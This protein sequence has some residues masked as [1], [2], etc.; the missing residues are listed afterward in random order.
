MVNQDYERRHLWNRDYGFRKDY[1]RGKRNTQIDPLSYPETA[2]TAQLR[3]NSY[4]S[5]KQERAAA[6]PLV[7]LSLSRSQPSLH[8][9]SSY[10][11]EASHTSEVAPPAWTWKKRVV[12]SLPS[13]HPAYTSNTKQDYD[14]ERPLTLPHEE[15]MERL[16]FVGELVSDENSI[17]KLTGL[18]PGSLNK[19][20]MRWC[21]VPPLTFRPG[22]PKPDPE[23]VEDDPEAPPPPVPLLAEITDNA[24]RRI[25][26]DV[27]TD[28]DFHEI[29]SNEDQAQVLA[30]HIERNE[31]EWFKS[32]ME[33]HTF[34]SSKTHP[35][36]SMSCNEVM[37]MYKD[38]G[39]LDSN[40]TN[41]YLSQL[42]VAMNVAEANRVMRETGVRPKVDKTLDLK[43]FIAMNIHVA[44]RKF[45]G[46]S[47][48][49]SPTLCLEMLF[50]DHL[51]AV[52]DGIVDADDL[53]K[54]LHEQN[55]SYDRPDD[56]RHVF[57]AYKVRLRKLFKKFAA[58]SD[59]LG[60]NNAALDL[61]EC[62]DFCEAMGLYN[63]NLT[64]RG[65]IRPFALSRDLNAP[66]AAG[67]EVALKWV[68]FIE[69]VVRIACIKFGS[70]ELAV[71]AGRSHKD[72]RILDDDDGESDS[73]ELCM[74]RLMSEWFG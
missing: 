47:K 57:K 9:L 15:V 1:F 54:K 23:E 6:N 44:L 74:A 56:I 51:T 37:E 36:D 28:H 7:R 42:F 26:G 2:K 32:L 55:E 25:W 39:C 19:R 70:N 41:V 50:D 59:K 29:M 35:V 53:R 4:L 58:G 69:F 14:N 8:R 66:A 67:G 46:P 72:D 24:L 33:L 22:T 52:A 11:S 3:R 49:L 48:L 65:V 73:I 27:G 17:N 16:A 45:Q 61:M 68:S 5:I 38:A 21:L 62:W 40:V 20:K 63:S 71:L 12:Q 30:C 10:S 64:K 34:Y 18:P 13:P 60:A 43:E 31:G